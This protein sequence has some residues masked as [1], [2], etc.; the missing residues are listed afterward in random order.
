MRGYQDLRQGGT[1][2]ESEEILPEEE[3]PILA[4][5]PTGDEGYPR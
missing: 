2:M 1:S 4:W 5:C 3:V